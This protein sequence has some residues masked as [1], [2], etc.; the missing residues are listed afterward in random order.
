MP[1]LIRTSNL[2]AQLLYSDGLD[3]SLPIYE[4]NGHTVSRGQ[5]KVDVGRKALCLSRHLN[6]GDTALISLND[7]PTL[8]SLFLACI[9]IGV[10]PAV[11]NPRCKESTLESIISNGNPKALFTSSAR[12]HNE[13]ISDKL[14]IFSDANVDAINFADFGLYARDADVLDHSQ[15]HPQPEDS[16]VYL[17]YTSGST[18]AP[19]AVMHSPHSTLSFCRSVAIDYLNAKP[20]KRS[21]SVPRMFFGYGM[22][23]SIFF[24]LYAGLHAYLHADWPSAERAAGIVESFDTAYLFA[25]PSL[26]RLLQPHAK[27]LSRLEVAV[28]A[29]APLPEP[30][31]TFW[32]NQGLHLKDGLGATEMGHIFMA[33]P[34]ALDSYSCA[35]TPLPGFHCRIV[36]PFGH[37]VID[38]DREGDLL[39]QGPSMALG[40]RGQPEETSARF[41]DGWYRT[42]DRVSRDRNGYYHFCGR[43]DDQFKVKGRWVTPQAV[44]TRILSRFSSISE[45]ALVASTPD[46][47]R[48]PPTLFLVGDQISETLVGEIRRWLR[49]SFESPMMPRKISVVCSLP[50]NDNG[51]VDRKAIGRLAHQTLMNSLQREAV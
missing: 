13:H 1:A 44:E 31:F 27:R 39:V 17:Q 11:I 30:E 46:N 2:T 47:D 37:T 22:G 29:G 5:L 33:Q 24:P 49:Q 43:A 48:H 40:Y 34:R 3:D 14:E 35:G 38:P 7:C 19:K 25:V 23:N 16:C 6:P 45:A 20:S 21:Y 4:F 8:V 51:K 41:I 26:Y 36:D 9:A 12:K 32:R 42:G 50:R 28:S 18:G 10:V 15:F